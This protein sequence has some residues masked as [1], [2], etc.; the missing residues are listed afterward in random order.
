[1]LYVSITTSSRFLVAVRAH[2]GVQQAHAEWQ[3]TLDVLNKTLAPHQFSL[4]PIVKL[5][6]ISRAAKMSEIDFVL[7]NPSSYVELEQLYQAKVLA[8]LNNKRAQTAQSEFGSVIF[9]H[10]T[11]THIVKLTDLRNKTMMAVSP[12]A[13]GG[14]RVAW[15]EMLEQGID[16]NNDLKSMQYTKS[17]TQSEVVLSVLAKKVDVGVVRTDLLERMEAAGKIDLRYLRVLNEKNMA[18]QKNLWAD[19]GSGSLPI[20]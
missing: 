1:M 13:F 4:V 20:V 16:P 6:E 2:H 5:D 19:S 18:L 10:A 7:T 8:T 12:P 14:W 17:R 3:S 9:T 11:N 15:L